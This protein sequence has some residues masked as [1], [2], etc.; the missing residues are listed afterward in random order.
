MIDKDEDM[1]NTFFYIV[2]AILLVGFVCL[3][4][5]I[6]YFCRLSNSSDEDMS[7]DIT[8]A[9]TSQ[10]NSR[11]GNRPPNINVSVASSSAIKVN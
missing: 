1:L 9:H 8:S 7:L 10:R 5:I 6:Y 2:I 4:A 3:F 11:F